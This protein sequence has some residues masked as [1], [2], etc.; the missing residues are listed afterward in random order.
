MLTAHQ[1]QRG[2]LSLP[3]DVLCRQCS[4]GR[5]LHVLDGARTDEGRNGL[6]SFGCIAVARMPDHT[7]PVQM[8]VWLGFILS[9]Y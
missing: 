9:R 2:F 4:R 7:V 8:S 6:K 5:L 1:M 3:K